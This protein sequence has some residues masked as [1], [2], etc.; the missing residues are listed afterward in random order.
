[1]RVPSPRGRECIDQ[2]HAGQPFDACRSLIVA[3]AGRSL[4]ALARRLRRPADRHTV[5]RNPIRIPATGAMVGALMATGFFALERFVLRRNAGGLIRPL[6][7]LAYF[8]LRSIS[9]SASLCSPPSWS[10]S[11]CSGGSRHWRRRFG[12]FRSH[13]LV[14]VGA[15]LLFS[16]NDL[17]GLACSSHSP[18]GAITSRASRTGRSCSSTC[19]PRPPSPS[20]WANS[21]V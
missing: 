21:A 19:A 15:N 18:R 13:L 8:A 17:L 2:R 16:V 5:C 14:V 10:P 12:C 20:D 4:V 7:F 9:T 3:R 1:M 6:P 11:S